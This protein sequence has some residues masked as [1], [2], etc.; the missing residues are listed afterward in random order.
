MGIKKKNQ[1]C[2]SWNHDILGKFDRV[3]QNLVET[4]RKTLSETKEL[5]NKE[6]TNIMCT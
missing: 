4:M 1:C 5:F 3:S 2:G 6:N